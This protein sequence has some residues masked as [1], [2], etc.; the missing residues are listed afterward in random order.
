MKNFAYYTPTQ[1]VFGKAVEEETGR[2]IREAG[3]SRVLLHYGGGSVERSGLLSRIRA[4]LEKEGL[5]RVELGGVVPNPRL[6]LVHE[7]IALG[8]KEGVDFVL[9][10]GGGS[11]IDSAKAIG[12]GLANEGEVWDFY[13]RKRKAKGCAPIGV[14]LTIAAAGSEMSSSCVITNEDGWIKR[15]YSSEYSRPRFAVMNPELTMTLSAYQTA[16]GCVDILMHTM[17]RYFYRDG[18]MELTDGIAES[19]L[20]TVMKNALIL[21]DDPSCYDAR[22]EIMWAGSLSHNGLTGCGTDGGDWA[23]HKIEHELSGLFDV[24]HGAGLAAVWGSWARYVYREDAARFARFAQ[25][26][27]GVSGAG[28]HEEMAEKGIKAME[29]FFRALN[30]PTSLAELG[31][32]PT[33]EEIRTM[34]EKCVRGVG[35]PVGVVRPLEVEDIENIYRMAK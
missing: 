12:Y 7:G 14:V 1:V 35:G 15:G 20:R 3:G 30:M 32:S 9:A 26:V 24:A 22:A 19:L 28:T 4:S 16:S 23:S 31:V 6:S 27:M 13:E 10:V 17:E 11:V 34:A 2:L 8:R 5:F 33:E 29:N 25:N 18:G 21:R